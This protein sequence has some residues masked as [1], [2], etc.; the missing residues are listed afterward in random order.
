MNLG[1]SLTK[2]K[3]P[4]SY[5]KTKKGVKSNLPTYLDMLQTN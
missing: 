2:N 4:N 3:Y 5:N 1:L